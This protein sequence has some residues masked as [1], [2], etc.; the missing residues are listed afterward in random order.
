M[1]RNDT[2]ICQHCDSECLDSCT[3]PGPRN[4][5]KCKH[6]KDG[7][8]CRSHCPPFKY[9]IGNECQSCHAN[10]IDSCTGPA[11]TIGYGGCD[12]CEHAIIGDN[13]QIVRMMCNL[14]FLNTSKK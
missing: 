2:G 9:K 7:P 12:A 6:V 14:N 4:C 10:C 13:D 5:G 1:T 11:N 8:V 3:G